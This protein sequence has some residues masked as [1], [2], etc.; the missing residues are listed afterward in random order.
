MVVLSDRSLSGTLL[1]YQAHMFCGTIVIMVLFKG[2]AE[3]RH[4]KILTNKYPY[5]VQKIMI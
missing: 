2:L 4:L 3:Q 5:F 1:Y